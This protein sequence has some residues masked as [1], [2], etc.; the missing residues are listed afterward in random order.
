MFFLDGSLDA[1]G[2]TF[3][4]IGDETVSFHFGHDLE[5]ILD[6]IERGQERYGNNFGCN[7]RENFS[8]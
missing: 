5:P 7:M 1:I 4:K 8:S 6:K 2:V 3:V